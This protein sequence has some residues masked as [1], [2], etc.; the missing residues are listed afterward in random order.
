MIAREA[1]APANPGAAPSLGE[2]EQQWFD[3]LKSGGMQYEIPSTMFW[4]EASTVTV[5]IQGPQA[6]ASAALQGP[7]GAAAIKVSNR[8][9]VVIAS[10]DDPNE[11]TIVPEQGTQDTQF[12]PS[13]AGA[14]WNYSVTPKYTGLG[15][16]LSITAWVLYPGHKGN[17]SQQ[18]PVYSATVDVHVP[19]FSDCIKR[20]IEGDPDCWLK[21]GLP[22]GGGFV[23]VAGV[24]GWFVKR[25]SR[26]KGHKPQGQ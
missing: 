15:Q 9:K 6:P 23:F 21:Y 11:F 7:A 26:R 19:S 8:M 22:G 4:K 24:V 10:P 12:V 14:I 25:H 18:L 3:Q 17:I 13:D 20:L 2:E 5:A 16:K 1:P